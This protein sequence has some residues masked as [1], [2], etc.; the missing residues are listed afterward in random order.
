LLRPIFY[1]HILTTP[2]GKLICSR[3][4]EDSP[5]A[6]PIHTHRNPLHCA[7]SAQYGGLIEIAFTQPAYDS[8]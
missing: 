4:S 5:A 6:I 3:K 7:V 1:L 8:T 2:K